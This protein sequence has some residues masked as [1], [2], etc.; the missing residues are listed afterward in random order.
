MKIID[1]HQHFWKYNTK[2]FDWVSDEMSVIKRDF[3]PGELQLIY[4]ENNVE[5][6]VAVQV[7][8]TEKE[9]NFFLSFAEEFD[10]IKGIV[11][12]VDLT[13]IDIEE[14]L[15]YWHQYKKL[16]G[17]RHILQGEKDRAF[18]LRPSFKNAISLLKKY[19]FTYDILIY[20][21]QLKYALELVKFFPDQKFVIDH[22]AKP[23]IKSG[24]IEQWKSDIA[25]FKNCQNVYCKISGMVTEANWNDYSQQTFQP[26]LDIVTA[27]FG[28]KRIMFGSD[29]PV[30]LV[31]A[32]YKKVLQIVKDYFF[33]FSA[34]EQNDIFSNNAIAFYDL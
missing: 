17:F 30:C 29:W 27:T 4:K 15:A 33:S 21:D 28:T 26:Y 34:D 22:L 19:N 16:K 8:Q 25:Q 32:S 18:M 23:Y 31:A 13:N 24:E 7:N 12:W 14:K 1:S 2:D 20:P 11:G 10:F 9:N 3:L 6:C 5:G